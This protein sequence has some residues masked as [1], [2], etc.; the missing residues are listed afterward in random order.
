M[1]ELDV[2]SNPWNR[3]RFAMGSK[4]SHLWF[5]GMII[6]L[7]AHYKLDRSCSM[8]SGNSSTCQA[9]QNKSFEFLNSYRYVVRSDIRKLKEILSLCTNTAFIDT[10]TSIDNFL[11]IWNQD[12]HLPSMVKGP[13]SPFFQQSQS[14]TMSNTF[15]LSTESNY[16][17]WNNPTLGKILSEALQNAVKN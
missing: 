14:W 1:S 8:V 10:E 9:F 15:E 13:L 2:K 4:V 3:I 16:H 17:F 6:K 12:E 11:Y 7:Y 5:I